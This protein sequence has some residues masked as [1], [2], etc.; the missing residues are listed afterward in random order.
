[1]TYISERILQKS[2]ENHDS[3]ARMI[4]PTGENS[5]P[6][7]EFLMKF[8][9]LVEDLNNFL[10]DEKINIKLCKVNDVALA[11]MQQLQANN[12]HLPEFEKS[13]LNEIIEKLQKV[14]KIVSK[15]P[16]STDGN[17]FN[18][19][20]QFVHY[21][22]LK[23]DEMKKLKEKQHSF[24]LKLIKN[25][26][27]NIQEIKEKLVEKLDETEQ[28]LDSF[29]PFSQTFHDNLRLIHD[30]MTFPERFPAPEE[31]QRN[32]WLVQCRNQVKDN[33]MTHLSLKFSGLS[34]TEQVDGRFGKIRP[35]M[36][37]LH[38]EQLDLW[39]NVK[40]CIE[41]NICKDRG[42]KK[43]EKKKKSWFSCSR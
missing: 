30:R 20:E 15:W 21:F 8:V 31:G 32:K 36:N 12:I 14:L 10:H 38:I 1:M 2:R 39:K 19:E 26:R 17:E 4:L 24:L 5:I 18:M 37:E 9:L 27:D 33:V 6:T 28:Q 16:F 40:D 22:S 35:I 13:T 43:S 42:K 41:K 3:L 23:V 11:R 25:A 29:I 34:Y 7:R